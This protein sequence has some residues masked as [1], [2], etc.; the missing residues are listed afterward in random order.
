MRRVQAR[1]EYGPGGGSLHG[2]LQGACLGGQAGVAWVEADLM[3][4]R[5]P[6]GSWKGDAAGAI[7][8]NSFGQQ[9]PHPW[10]HEL[11]QG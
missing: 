9:Q 3:M 11:Q 2:S 10:L 1:P 6:N 7:P 4:L 5:D 8:N